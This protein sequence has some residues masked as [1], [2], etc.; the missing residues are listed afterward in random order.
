LT[1]ICTVACSFATPYTNTVVTFMVLRLLTAAFM[2]GLVIST[3][4]YVTE[5]V[6]PKHRTKVSMFYHLMFPLGYIVETIVAYKTRNWVQLM[7]V[8]NVISLPFIVISIITPESPRWLLATNKSKQGKK[9]IKEM[10][11][12]SGQK[13]DENFWK[14]AEKDSQT[15]SE[16]KKMTKYS[17]FGL[18]KYSS[19]RKVIIKVM[20]CWAAT[21]SVYFGVSLNAGSISGDFFLNS[22]INGVLE[23]ISYLLGALLIDKLGR[24]LVISSSF[25]VTSVGLLVSVLIKELLA[26]DSSLQLVGIAFAFVGKFGISATLSLM[27][28]LSS[29][30]FPTVIRS[31]SIGLGSIAA[32]IGS[33]FAPFVISINKTISW[34]PSAIFTC[35]GFTAVAVSLLLPETRDIEFIETVEEAEYFYKYGKPMKKF[36]ETKDGKE[37]KVF[38]INK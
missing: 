16:N 1:F 12:L 29:E 34:L 21:Y 13:I 14:Q 36:S 3:Y 38:T 6:Q 31:N 10:S 8:V 35:V 23:M 7:L 5:L 24:R 2:I 4:T 30:V 27:Y 33:I 17:S 15:S 22:I 11:R 26:V 20:F 9:V 18:F 32:R 19:I 37:M 25:F 28:L